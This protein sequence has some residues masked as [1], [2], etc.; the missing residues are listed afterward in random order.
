MTCCAPERQ[1]VEELLKQHTDGRGRY[2]VCKR[3]LHLV[4]Y[5]LPLFT[6]LDSFDTKNLMGQSPDLG[7]LMT[8]QRT[9]ARL[10][11]PI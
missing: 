2:V 1:Y 8:A 6:F 9:F 11:L 3:C 5:S 7:L 4:T 10:L